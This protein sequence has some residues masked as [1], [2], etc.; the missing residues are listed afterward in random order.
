MTKSPTSLA[1]KIP[2]SVLAILEKFKKD[3]FEIYIVGGV[4]RDLI[5]GKKAYDW[6]FTTNA[7]P[8][9]ILK[10]F[11]LGFYDNK[12]GTVGIA[13]KSHEH[14]Y[15]ITTYRTEDGYSDKRR[16]DS[17]SWGKSLAEDL[18]RRDFTINA[19]ALS[20]DGKVIDFHSGQEDLNNKLIRSVGNPMKR[21]DEDSLR[22]IRAIRIATELG[23]EIEEKTLEAIKHHSSSIIYV[24]WERIKD[25]LIKLLKS[26]NSADGI[27][28]LRKSNL[29]KEIFPELEIAFGVEQKS[30][31]RHHKFDVGTH[32]I[33][34]LRNCPSK[35][36][37]VRFATLIHD[38]GKPRT[39]K[40]TDEGVITFYNHEVIGARMAKDIANR[41]RLSKKDRDRIWLLVRRH[42]F[43]VDE[44]QTDS[45][46]RRFIKNVGKEN[47]QDILDLR[48]GDRLGGGATETSWRLE[49]FKKRLEEVQKQP[50][51]VKDLKIN[52]N[53]VMEILKIPGGP[54]VGEILNKLFAE[55]EEDQTKNER[56]YLLEKIKE[57][58]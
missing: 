55:V 45:S 31:K 38:I 13:D 5:M 42:Q 52:G 36:P 48:T 30:P 53:D 19:L 58:N 54:K 57:L 34:S 1:K 6:D 46:I 56:E 10:I 44:R 29:L 17:V 20:K 41:L 51:S 4:V 14:P 27:F 8:E 25:E 16:P 33:E 50:F 37:I 12:F 11:P 35:D 15:E 47:L 2:S 26:E 18:S 43:T 49:K 21:F 3:N 39:Q 22:M 32:L 7:T 40:I 28:L 24:P 23:F 9:E